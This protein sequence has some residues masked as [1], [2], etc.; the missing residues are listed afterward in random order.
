M[1]SG[2]VGK[3][4]YRINKT[5]ALEKLRDSMIEPTESE[6][7]ETN[8]DIE[9]LTNDVK[10][11]PDTSPTD[12]SPTDS[13]RTDTSPTDISPTKHIPDGDNPRKN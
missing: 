11:F 2:L 7:L 3:E 10:G 13:S 12:I 6:G 4:S 1:E 5:T 9:K 8:A